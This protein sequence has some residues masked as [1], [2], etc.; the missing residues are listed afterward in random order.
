M[1]IIAQLR[2]RSAEIK[3]LFKIARIG[4]FGSCAHNSE[5]EDS[6]VDVLVEFAEPV[7]FFHFIDVKEFLEGILGRRVDLVTRRALKPII[8]ESILKEVVFV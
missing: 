4:V 8:R 1:D 5:N 3:N 7:D 2:I 6:D